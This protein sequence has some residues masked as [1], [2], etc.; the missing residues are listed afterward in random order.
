MSIDSATERKKLQRLIDRAAKA[1]SAFYLANKAL[2]EF[3]V[4]KY[5]CE[6]A[7]VDCDQIIDAVQG[8][9]GCQPD[10]L[11]MTLM[12]RW[13]KRWSWQAMADQL[14]TTASTSTPSALGREA[15]HVALNRSHAELHSVALAPDHALG[16]QLDSNAVDFG[17]VRKRDPR[18]S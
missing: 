1:A 3:C 15:G 14:P 6:P 2:C 12:R 16:S 8:G 17:C 5:G 4:E 13:S 11:P 18:C 7:D 9:A 10:F